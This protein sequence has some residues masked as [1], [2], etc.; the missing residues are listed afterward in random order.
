[1]EYDIVTDTT[2]VGLIRSV[3]ILIADGWE[4]LGGI[5]VSPIGQLLQA[6]VKYPQ[7][8]VHASAEDAES[9]RQNADVMNREIAKA[10]SRAVR[11]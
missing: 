1:M 3:D 7:L 9:F 4:P 6:M 2:A 5:A 10:M 8:K 11:G